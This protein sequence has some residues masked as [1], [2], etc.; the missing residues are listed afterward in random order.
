MVC[1]GLKLCQNSLTHCIEG[2]SQE[3]QSLTKK[4]VNL[5]IIILSRAK[6]CI[7]INSITKSEDHSLF[8][9][10]EARSWASEWFGFMS[11][12]LLSQLKCKRDNDASLQWVADSPLIWLMIG[13]V[14]G[15][16]VAFGLVSE[17]F[18]YYVTE[19]IFMNET[20]SVSVFLPV[21]GHC[22][23]LISFTSC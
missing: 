17:Y 16:G 22:M 9:C 21:W 18:L 10:G 4:T 6:K 14:W 7:L 20:S 19:W 12:S 8:Y 15:T 23:S 2:L 1:T 5:K 13:I 11:G 3:L